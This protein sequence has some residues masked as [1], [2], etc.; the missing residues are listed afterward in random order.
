M[1][2][3]IEQR[4]NAKTFALEWKDKGYEKGE[5]QIFWL[6]LLRDVFGIKQPEKYI[7][8]EDQVHIDRTSFID[9]YI[10]STKVLIEQKSIDKDLNK[11]IKQSDG[12]YLTPVQQARKYIVDSPVSKHPRWVVTCNFK[13]FYVYDMERP[14]CEPERIKLSEL[15]KDY[16]RLSFLVANENIHIQ[17]EL[18]V[19]IQAGDIVGLIYD[20]LLSQYSDPQ[21]EHSLKSLNVLCVRIVFCLYAEDA[22]IFGYRDMFCDYLTSMPRFCR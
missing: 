20:A 4:K 19:S 10:K 11:G 12:T 17:R 2:T 8:F 7:K 16:Y 18:E 5:S 21:N 13:E 3:D 1:I 6:S 15:E 14:G 9:G 22:G